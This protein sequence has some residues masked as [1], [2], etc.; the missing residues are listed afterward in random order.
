[1]T[2]RRMAPERIELSG[3]ERRPSERQDAICQLITL[4]DPIDLPSRS[5]TW[6]YEGKADRFRVWQDLPIRFVNIT[7]HERTA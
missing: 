3:I 2:R 7:R 6:T 1:M 4:P 5:H